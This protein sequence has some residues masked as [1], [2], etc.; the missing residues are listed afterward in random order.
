MAKDAQGLLLAGSPD[1]LAAFDQAVDDYYGW[2]GDPIGLLQ[3]AL[4]RDPA[5]T[6]GASA[7]ASLYLLNG[8]RGDNPA[9]TTSLNAAAAAVGG[10]SSRER[11]HLDAAKA[12]AAGRIIGATDIWEDILVD[13]PVGD[14]LWRCALRMTAI[15]ISAIR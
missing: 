1:S 10:A 6:L 5:F 9:V 3:G 13:H 15:S 11:R 2:K 14:V 12:W 4:D 7:I 8:F